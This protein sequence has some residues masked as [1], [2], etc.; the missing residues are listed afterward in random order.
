[1]PRGW[2][3][4]EVRSTVEDYFAMLE[5]ELADE[6]FN[7]A[8]HRRRLSATLEGR[9]SGAIERK[10]QNISAILQQ[11][12]LPTIDGYKPL[13]NYQRAEGRQRIFMLERRFWS[14]A[15]KS[16]ARRST[17]TS[18]RSIGSFISPALRASSP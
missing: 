12:A 16:P 13:G 7:K 11:L 18:T 10:H 2:S 6:A 15:T 5:A 9:S 17:P 3:F 1:V 14:L 8:Q 4:D